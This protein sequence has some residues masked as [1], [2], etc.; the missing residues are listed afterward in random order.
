M[1]E[2]EGVERKGV[3]M[4]GVRRKGGGR[5]RGGRKGK[6]EWTGRVDRKR[7]EGWTGIGGTGGQEKEGGV[8]KKRVD[9]KGR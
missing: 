8:D 5:K 2:R 1:H 9:I 7:R 3:E 4:K 6:M